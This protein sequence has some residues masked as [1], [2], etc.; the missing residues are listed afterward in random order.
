MSAEDVLE[1]VSR[2]KLT[3]PVTFERRGTLR[4]LIVEDGA[5]A[6]ASSNRS[7]EQLGTIL[8][9]SGLLAESALADAL[10]ARAETGVPLGRLLLLS[11][12][13]TEADVIAI[14]STKIRETVTDV[15]TWT[16]GHFDIVPRAQASVPGLNAQ[17][18][19]DVCLTVARRRSSR[20][21]AIMERLET[22]DATFYAA[23]LTAAPAA[24]PH[25]VIDPAAVWTHA[26]TGLNAAA[27]SAVMSGER[28]A[29][30]NILADLVEA[31]QL[32]IERRRRQRTDSAIELAAGALGRLRQGH[33]QQALAM[34]KQ[35]LNQ[36]PSHP[37]A[38][39]VFAHAERACVAEA[40]KRLLVRHCVPRRRHEVTDEIQAAH[41][42]T[43]IEID[44][45]QRVD[46]RWDLMSLI[47]SAP[48]RQAEALLAFARLA[49]VGIV[50]LPA[51]T[52]KDAAEA[53]HP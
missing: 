42:L 37:E 28:F 35:A 52:D 44:L 47:Q 41:N 12:L 19:V 43:P 13:T 38:R 8:V 39:A 36:D 40:A 11:G 6:H 51:G 33:R 5:I 30:Y 49:E 27:I 22:D 53:S 21:V 9:R 48:V 18:S 46:G 2:R 1:W 29:T 32:K 10:R 23:P 4:T 15:V 45:A 34:A 14:L 26:T 17:L 50:D 20:M 3:A 31:G 7:D 16:D 25:E 24:A